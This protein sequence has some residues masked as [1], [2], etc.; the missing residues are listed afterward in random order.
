[1]YDAQSAKKLINKPE[2]VVCEMLEGI[3]DMNPNVT[4]LEGFP[5]IKV[6][7]RREL[8]SSKVALISGGGSGHEPAHAGYVGKGM[9]SAAV[10]GD[11]FASP[12]VDAV[13][14]G[15]RAV[16]GPAGC[17][18]IVKN[19]TGDRINFGLAAERAKM[20]G[21]KVEIVFVADDCALVQDSIP[22]RR[23]L[24][25]TVFVHKV[26]GAAAEAGLP[27]LG[28]NSVLAE[29]RMA[30]EAVGTMGVALSVC[31]LPGVKPSDRLS[32]GNMELGLGIHGEPG[33]ETAPI[34]SADEVAARILE[35]IT[36]YYVP[37]KEG[38]EVGLMVNSLGG[39]PSMELSIVGRAAKKWLTSKG[40]Q[41]VRC[42][43]GSFM[44]AIDMIGLSLTVIRLSPP[45]TARLDTP[46]EAPG[47]PLTAAPSLSS[48]AAPI[49]VP[50]G[51]LEGT[52]V[53]NPGEPATP[54]AE[55][56]RAAIA[57]AA[58][59]IMQ[60]EEKLT[61]MDQ[62]VGDGDCGLTFARGARAILE[63]LPKYP[64]NH[65]AA[66][67]IQ[68]G[69]TVRRSMGGSSGGLY[70][71]F[72]HAAAGALKETSP[73]C[74]ASDW[75]TALQAGAAAMMRYGGAA[76]GMRTMLDALVPAAESLLSALVDG[77]LPHEAAQAAA[78]AAKEGVIKTSTMA[79]SAGRSSYVPAAQL[80]NT[81]D[82]GAAA[83]AIWLE[84]VAM[85][86]R[87]ANS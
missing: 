81:P 69:L 36:S 26:A 75:G 62:I 18:L 45:L 7:L 20:E 84:S 24:A 1:M 2:D 10:C 34:A 59:A 21:F 38:E 60:A 79:A 6:I 11:V 31:A 66:T 22:G 35:K 51:K 48:A 15:I 73:T 54:S 50:A 40:V 83:A 25:G 70:D 85:T 65:P 49:P 19:Y 29:A 28:N 61:G 44:T 30:A 76:P 53:G 68:L 52:I 78:D 57:D 77:A 64:L 74:S 17:L 67:A 47:W 71:L 3:C 32:S 5:D 9:L 37:L 23:G 41:V 80:N 12:S 56:L 43:C 46:C 8:D 13:L 82:P 72:F 33:A 87:S 63:D 42:Y 86:L 27:L 55:T 39:T 14:A 16:T 4:R 58:N